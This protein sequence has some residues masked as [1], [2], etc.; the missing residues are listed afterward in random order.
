MKAFVL[1][2]LVALISVAIAREDVLSAESKPDLELVDVYTE[3]ETLIAGRNFRVYAVVRNAGDVVIEDMFWI[4]L[5]TEGNNPR[6][7]RVQDNI[8]PGEERKYYF[9][10]VPSYTDS[11]SHQLIVRVDSNSKDA[12][13]DNVIDESD[14]KNNVFSVI[15]AVKRDASGLLSSVQGDI[16]AISSSEGAFDSST[17]LIIVAVL[18]GLLSAAVGGAYMLRKRRAESA[19]PVVATT[20][21]PVA[22]PK[23][24][25]SELKQKK[26]ELDEVIRLAKIKFYKRQ[27]DE[28]SY[29]E[30]VKENQGKLISI[31]A[32]ISDLEK[33]DSN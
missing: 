9:D 2:C 29:K 30:I 15:V 18:V 5:L 28:D 25:L 14:E 33:K 7:R 32:K 27:I 12:N 26:K 22:A 13:I 10:D 3:P 8:K 16:S 20:A 11:G 19:P 31:E 17:T 4:E 23:S 6:I 24:Q 21:V 1:L